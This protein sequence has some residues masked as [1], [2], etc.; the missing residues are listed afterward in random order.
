MKLEGS[1]KVT[2]VKVIFKFGYDQINIPYGKALL[3]NISN[4]N[5]FDGHKNIANLNDL[6]FIIDGEI[7]QKVGG[8]VV[9][10]SVK[11]TVEFGYDQINISYRKAL[12]KKHQINRCRGHK[13]IA[14]LN[15]LVFII[16]GEISSRELVVLLF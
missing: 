9:V 6:I 3:K 14:K 13:N 11:V 10:T 7:S 2:S 5:K 12:L 4:P 1:M 8:I 16:N 15:D